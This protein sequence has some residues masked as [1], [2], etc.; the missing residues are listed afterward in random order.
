MGDIYSQ[1]VCTI[2]ATAAEDSDGGLFVERNAALL[3]PRRIEATW[4][5]N[6]DAMKHGDFTYPQ[7]GL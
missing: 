7:A 6:P 5:P 4:S 1:A 2:A 3:Q